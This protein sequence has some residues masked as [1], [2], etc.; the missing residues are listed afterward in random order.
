MN[1]SSRP[2]QAQPP[3]CAAPITGPTA[4]YL[5]ATV[6]E[7]VPK[8]IPV[9][10][11]RELAA[12]PAILAREEPVWREMPVVMLARVHVKIV[13]AEPDTGSE[14]HAEL[15]SLRLCANV[16]EGI[17]K[18][19]ARLFLVRGF[20]RDA[21]GRAL[22]IIALAMKNIGPD[23]DDIEIA[24]IERAAFEA[25]ENARLEREEGE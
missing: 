2:D 6:N 18:R 21:T 4:R 19:A 1:T 12:L 22:H 7:S 8:H 25:H 17:L 23:M 3:R 10:S 9:P 13:K 24:G 11:S 16:E 14:A 15:Y 5:G 20:G